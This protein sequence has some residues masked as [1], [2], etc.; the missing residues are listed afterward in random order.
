[1]RRKATARSL[2]TTLLHGDNGSDVY[3]ETIGFLT[4]KARIV[5][6]G[7]QFSFKKRVVP[8]PIHLR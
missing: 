7:G 1:M 4:E 2:I 8:L 5:S 6:L 3:L